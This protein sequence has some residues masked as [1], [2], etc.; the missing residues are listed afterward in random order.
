M[1]A[2]SAPG[3]IVPTP[4]LSPHPGPVCLPH[5]PL[6]IRTRV[7]GFGARPSPGGLPFTATSAK[8]SLPNKLKFTGTGVRTSRLFRGHNAAHLAGLGDMRAR[9]RLGASPLGKRTQTGERRF[10][11]RPWRGLRMGGGGGGVLSLQGHLL[12]KVGLLHPNSV[13]KLITRSPGSTQFN[14]EHTV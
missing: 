11:C 14:M 10:G 2:P 9:R 8:T 3:C 13:S 4:P 7:M 12:H 5:F 1:L 6:H